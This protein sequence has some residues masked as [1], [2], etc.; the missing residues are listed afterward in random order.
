LD[1]IYAK[2][3][4]AIRR[5]YLSRTKSAEE[6][7]ELT[8]T[9]FLRLLGSRA[10]PNV[11]N[12]RSYIFTVARNLLLTMQKKAAREKRYRV[13]LT[14]QEL[15]NMLSTSRLISAD[16]TSMEVDKQ[17]FINALRKLPA[18]QLKAW[19]LHYISGLNYEQIAER[20]G[21]S[22]HA[23]H[24]YISKTMVRIRAHFNPGPDSDVE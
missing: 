14:D 1:D 5:Y 22:H 16:D 18:A 17:C 21:I 10:L 7:E 13:S 19:N 9:V 12:P 2:F 8:Q 4:E 11:R 15:E 20:M 6:A 3:R 23:V 24:K